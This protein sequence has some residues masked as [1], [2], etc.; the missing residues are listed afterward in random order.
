MVA[1]MSNEP[2]KAERS[3]SL[4]L[5]FGDRGSMTRLAAQLHLRR[6]TLSQ[7][8]E[9]PEQHIITIETLTGISRRDLRPDL[10]ANM[11]RLVAAE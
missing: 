6:Q 9:V 7:W 3:A 4:K 11:P 8:T 1:H 2:N 10:Y 5:L